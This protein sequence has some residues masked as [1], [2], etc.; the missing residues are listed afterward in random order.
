MKR[1]LRAVAVAGLLGGAVG[2]AGRLPV[3]R[4]GKQPDGSFIVSSGQRVEPGAIAFDGRPIDLA[5][6]PTGEFIAVLNQRSV[7]LATRQGVIAGS[8]A[9]L[10]DGAGYR[11]AVW[12]PDGTRLFVSVSNG[13]VQELKL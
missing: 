4:M 12:S 2:A 11:G 13:F 6:H 9:E 1:A 3:V 5:L 8:A 7:F 10:E